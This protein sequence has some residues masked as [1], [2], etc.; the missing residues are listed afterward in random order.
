[1]NLEFCCPTLFGLE[2]IVAD[3]LRFGGKLTDVRAENG[4]VLFTGNEQTLIWANMNLRCAERVLIRLASFPA[5]HFDELFEGTKAIP[6]ENFLPVHASFPVKG[7]SLDSKLFSVPDCQKIIKKA[8]VD[9]LGAHY[10]ISWFE[11]DGERYQIQFSIMRDEVEIFLDTSGAGLHKRGYRANANAAPL[12]ETLAAA[13]VKLARWR[14]RDPIVDPFCGSGTIPIEA[15]MIALNRAPGLMRTYD[16]EKWDWIQ[17]TRWKEAREQAIAAVRTGV[18]LSIQA[19]DID[20]A[21]VSLARDNAGKAGV[22]QFIRFETADALVRSY[23]E[24]G[25][26][27]ANPPYGER[28]LDHESAQK[29]Y[30]GMGRAIGKSELRQYYLTSDQEFERFYG[31]QADKRRKLYNGMIRCDLYMYFKPQE[32]RRPAHSGQNHMDKPKDRA[33]KLVRTGEKPRGQ[34]PERKT[35]SK[36]SRE[37]R[38]I[39]RG[40]KKAPNTRG[41]K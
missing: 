15:A 4:R 7:H 41:V 28:L 16:A 2:G 37:K 18:E 22:E 36:M 17:E 26:L 30:R 10:G 3:E 6:W 20:E 40:D 34:R 27:F 33:G 14:G 25:V 5:D 24:N 9:R 31:Y 38:P 35:E 32:A 29:L 23:P 12:R 19:S 8:I 39:S 13:M 11:E 1:M 21:S